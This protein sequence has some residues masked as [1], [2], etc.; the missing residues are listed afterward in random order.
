MK[1]LILKLCFKINHEEIFQANVDDKVPTEII[2]DH[3]Y[4]ILQ[5]GAT[6]QQYLKEKTYKKIIISKI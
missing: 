3:D 5:F 1:S 6:C 4:S 2:L